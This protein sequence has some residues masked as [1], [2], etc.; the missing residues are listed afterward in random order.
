MT[1]PLRFDPAAAAADVPERDREAR[2]EELLL[3]GL[4]HY[5]SG[6]HEQAINVWTR[7]LFL[8]RGHARARA[9]I[10]RARSAVSER[11]REGEELIHSGAAAFQRGD[12]DAARRLITSGVERGAATDEAFAL[13]ERLDRVE[14]AGVPQEVRSDRRATHAVRGHA[15]PDEH[16]DAGRSRL[17]WVAA[18]AVIGVVAA[19][20]ALALLWTRGESW[21]PLRAGSAPAVVATGAS[22]RLPVPSPAEVWIARARALHD[23]GRLSEALAALEGIRQGDPLRVTADELRAT[24]QRRLLESA[25]AS[26]PRRIAPEPA[27]APPVDRR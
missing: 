24:I 25:R 2:V 15:G 26:R 13:L 17:A 4:D 8:D 22:E 27:A 6:Q 10:E 7:V 12:A 9:Y 5:F 1:D 19:G 14:A 11:Q 16:R 21:L 3:I 23:K 20:V 18:G